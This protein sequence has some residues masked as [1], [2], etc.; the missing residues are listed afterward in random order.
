MPTLYDT[1]GVERGAD[2][3]ALRRAYRRLARKHHPDINPDPRSHDMMARINEAFETLMDPG[4]RE[5]YD[6]MLAGGLGSPNLND[7]VRHR[8]KQPVVVKLKRRLRA[9]QTPIYAVGFDPESGEALST[10]F[11]NEMFRWASGEE[12]SDRTRIEQSL[13]SVIRPLHEGRV[14]TAGA[15]ENLLCFAALGLGSWHWRTLVDEWIGCLA[16]SPDGKFLATGSV[17]S[18]FEVRSTERGQ[19]LY[20]RG[21]HDGSVTA[22]GWS[23]DGRYVATGSSDATVRVRDAQNGDTLR[24]LKAIRGTVTAVAFSPDGRFLVSAAADLSIRVFDLSSGD[25][26]KLLYGHE[27][28]VECLAFHPNGW[29]FA[30]AARDGVVGLWIASEGL[31]S[32]RIAASHRPVLSVAFSPDGEHLI[33]GG[34][35][36]T[37]REWSITVKD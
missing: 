15:G 26:V 37:L 32:V 35:D 31:G 21:D 14:L 36:K 11:D 2:G 28:P 17:Q 6:A 18:G 4:R 24:L 5:E 7:E 30:S 22:I 12:P 23:P 1:L 9:H 10:S 16:I 3:S 20:R 34:L 29:L 13:I 27:K 19:K 33:A 8:A 25:L